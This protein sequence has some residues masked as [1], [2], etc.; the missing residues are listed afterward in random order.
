MPGQIATFTGTYDVSQADINHGSIVD[1]AT[2]QGTTPSG[3]TRE[4]HLQHGDGDRDAVAE[5]L[6]QQVGNPDDRDGRRPDRGLHL[7]R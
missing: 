1:H 2:T 6:H 3:G 4:R 5:T 7:H